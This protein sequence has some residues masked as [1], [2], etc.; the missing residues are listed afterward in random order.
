MPSVSKDTRDLR[1]PQ[2]LGEAL[3]EAR[4]YYNLPH[5]RAAYD[6]AYHMLVDAEQTRPEP[7]HHNNTTTPHQT[8]E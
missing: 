2:K 7:Q 8:W 3:Q 6:G 1:D 5:L 4:Q